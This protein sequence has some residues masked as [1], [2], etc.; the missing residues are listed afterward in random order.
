MCVC[1]LCGKYYKGYAANGKAVRAHMENA[2]KY[3]D[4]EK[5]LDQININ[6]KLFDFITNSGT[7]ASILDSQDFRGFCRQLNYNAPRRN[8]YTEYLELKFKEKKSNLQA[9]LYNRSVSIMMDGWK[10]QACVQYIAVSCVYLND[11]FIQKLYTLAVTEVSN[12]KSET[13]SDLIMKLKNEFNIKITSVTSDNAPNMVKSIKD[14][15]ISNVRCFVHS[16]QLA[17]NNVNFTDVVDVYLTLAKELRTCSNRKVI[18]TS[19]PSY[20]VTRWNSIYAVLSKISEV[21]EEL[22]IYY[23]KISKLITD[24]EKYKRMGIKA[25]KPND[26]LYKYIPSDFIVLDGILKMLSPINSLTIELESNNITISL[27]YLKLKQLIHEMDDIEL[28]EDLKEY[29]IA[30]RNNLIER[31]NNI[32]ND[33]FIPLMCCLLDLRTKSYIQNCILFS[34]EELRLATTSLKVIYDEEKEDN[35]VQIDNS[36]LDSENDLDLYLSCKGIKRK[37]ADVDNELERFM[38]Y[39]TV[40]STKKN[41]SELWLLI[42]HRFP[43]LFKISQKYLACPPTSCEVERIFSLTG[44]I[45]GFNRSSLSPEHLEMKTM[46]SRNYN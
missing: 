23:N 32:N 31:V 44:R 39:N 36:E 1:V 21:K 30:I 18:S 46:I 29:N 41:I 2:H 13:I 19:I 35:Y 33:S 11:D 40:N 22:V 25:E 14:I 10:S 7:S 20:T 6:N 43:N 24:F 17:I 42:Q 45:S 9:E 3:Q 34:N 27:A 5:R 12:E 16:I 37:I 4:S 26:S 28:P 38:Q 8:T 15:K